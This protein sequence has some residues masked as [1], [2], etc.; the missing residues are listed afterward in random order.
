MPALYGHRNYPRSL[1]D[2]A[3]S[4]TSLVNHI[5]MALFWTICP[6]GCSVCRVFIQYFLGFEVHPNSQRAC[7]R[8]LGLSPRGFYQPGSGWSQKTLRAHSWCS[9]H[10]SKAKLVS[11][12]SISIAS[13]SEGLPAL[14]LTA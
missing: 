14:L 3:S 5:Q 10:H 12:A 11:T 6:T 13:N 4:E 1:T 2:N 7:C 9:H 8:L